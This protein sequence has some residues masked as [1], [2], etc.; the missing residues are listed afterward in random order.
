MASLHHLK[1]PNEI[2]LGAQPISTPWKV[3]GNGAKVVKSW[4]KLV[5]KCP[6]DILPFATNVSQP[7]LCKEFL[8]FLFP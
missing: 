4:R 8:L 5:E 3:L 6:E 7:I 2:L 1:A